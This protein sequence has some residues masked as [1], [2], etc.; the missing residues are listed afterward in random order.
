M[1]GIDQIAL[2]RGDKVAHFGSDVPPYPNWEMGISIS[3]IE[4]FVCHAQVDIQA[5]ATCAPYRPSFAFVTLP[6][7]NLSRPE[8]PELLPAASTGRR[9]TQVTIQMGRNTRT[10]MRRKRTKK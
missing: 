1:N 6:Y 7:V 5:R 3:L 4:K 2:A 8:L 9:M 10:I